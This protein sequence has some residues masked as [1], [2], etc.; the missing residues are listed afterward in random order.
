NDDL[1]FADC[2]SGFSPHIEI[3]EGIQVI[4][5]SLATFHANTL[6]TCFDACI[7]N[8]LVNDNVLPVVCRSAHYDSISKFCLLFS[9]SIAPVGNAHY[10]S[11]NNVIYMEKI[12]ISDRANSYC[13]KA[14][15]RIPQYILVGH[16]TA[17]ID[18]KSQS[19]CIEICLLS[20]ETV[21]FTCRSV[22]HFYEFR[23][24]NCILNQDSARTDP[25]YFTSEQELR[26]DYIE[27]EECFI[28]GIL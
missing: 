9:T 20:M 25:E 8:T 15:R 1:F 16:A 23:K 2:V 24:A 14:L 12:C 22:M 7:K 4:A 28:S 11:N 27:L 17:V 21:G 3:I 10:I 26:V 18:V 6:E 19:Q 5:Q 13:T